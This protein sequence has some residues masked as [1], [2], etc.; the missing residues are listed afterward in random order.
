VRFLLGISDNHDGAK[1]RRVPNSRTSLGVTVT[2]PDPRWRFWQL[3]WLARAPQ[4]LSERIA[5]RDD[6]GCRRHSSR[7]VWHPPSRRLSGH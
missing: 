2:I 3:G 1:N 6:V 4:S 7:V 5:G